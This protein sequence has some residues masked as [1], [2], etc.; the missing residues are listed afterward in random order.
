MI[1][2]LIS[3]LGFLVS[4]GLC[5]FVK[6]EF[7]DPHIGVVMLAVVFGIFAII[8]L[9]GVTINPV[10]VQ[11]EILEFHALQETF[12][13]A[14]TNPQISKFELATIQKSVAGENQWLA[15]SKFWAKHPLTNWFYP[16][17]ILLLEP[18]K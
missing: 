1:F 2:T 6:D 13:N 14:R 9:V 10:C 18:I 4:I 17:D 11:A 12:Q 16:K 15:S 8:T 7:N 3:W 5:F